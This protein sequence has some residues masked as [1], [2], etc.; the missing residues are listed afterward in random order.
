MVRLAILPDGL[1]GNGSTSCATL[2]L[3]AATIRQHRLTAS[4]SAFVAQ[5][6]AA[7]SIIVFVLAVM[8]VLHELRA[9]RGVPRPRPGSRQGGVVVSANANLAAT[10]SMRGMRGDMPADEPFG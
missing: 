4:S 7:P 6:I 9:A 2:A 1:G 3:G 8:C 10:N 5:N